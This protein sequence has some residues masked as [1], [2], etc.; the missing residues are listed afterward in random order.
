MPIQ[1]D[2]ALVARL[3][4]LNANYTDLGNARRLVGLFGADLRFCPQHKRWLVW[5][6]SRWVWDEDG[7]INL[8]AKSVI[9]V[10]HLQASQEKND[11]V[12]AK[13]AGWAWTSESAHRI[14]AMIKL[15]ATEPR[16]PVHP[17][18]LDPDPML[19]GVANGTV[20]LRTGKLRASRREDFITKQAAVRF[21]PSAE[22]PRWN[23]FASRI[24]DGPKGLF[25]YHQRLAGY[26]LTGLARE[27]YLFIPL[28]QG[29]NGK[30]VFWE[31]LGT[32]MGNYAATTPPETLMKRKNTGGPSPD[33]ARLPGVRLALASEP[34]EASVLA[35]ALVKRMTGQDTIYCRDLYGK[36]FEFKPQ[37]KIVLR[38]NDKPII[39]SD[40][41]A[42]WRRIQLI[43]YPVT[44]PKS[45]RNKELLEQ[46]EGE[47]PGILNWVLEGLRAYLRDG[48]APPKCI[49][50][51]VSQ[52]RSEMDILGD[53]IEECCEEDPHA[54]VS[55][56]ELYTSYRNWS[57]SSGHQPVSKKRLSQKL[58]NRGIERTR[59]GKGRFYVGL[60]LKT[61]DLDDVSNQTVHGPMG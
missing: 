39:R 29:A 4:S 11:T 16:I 1:D 20:D 33:L 26:C 7:R 53:W 31:T 59:T 10:M 8:Y 24:F 61:I 3:A 21:D 6:G 13:L 45:E 28:G 56:K 38:T 17:S 12:R 36:P 15:A 50:D 55:A 48:L 40:S 58:Q 52:Y 57:Q 25:E 23:S 30:T 9:K 49:Q 34:D 14:E 54:K 60:A 2:S 41:Y 44:I 51:A 32:L 46:L 27:H 19:L 22:C 42:T 37:F 35:E 18:Q 43:P 47:L 5:D